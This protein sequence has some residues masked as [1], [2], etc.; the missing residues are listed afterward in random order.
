MSQHYSDPTRTTDPHALPDVEV[1]KVDTYNQQEFPT[2]IHDSEADELLALGWYFWY[3]APGC[4]PDSDPI[5]PY[6]SEAE[7]VA[8]AQKA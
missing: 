5:G 8:A 7:A 6:D 3:C 1:F 2:R 4:L